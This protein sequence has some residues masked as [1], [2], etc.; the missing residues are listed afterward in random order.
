MNSNELILKH[1]KNWITSFV[2][3]LNLCPFAQREMDRKTVRFQVSSAKNIRQ[4]LADA[5]QEMKLLDSKREIE[6]TLLI[7]PSLFKN[8]QGYLDFIALLES[9]LLENNY[10]GIYQMAT[11]HPEYCFTNEEPEDVS[12]YTNRSPYPMIHFLR[13]KS[14]EEALKYHNAEKVPETNIRLLR[15]LGLEEVKKRLAACLNNQG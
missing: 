1:T 3:Q 9:V 7:F 4:A 11:F 13:E 8:F 12:N 2:L 10:E 6:T 5:V 15:T 14:I